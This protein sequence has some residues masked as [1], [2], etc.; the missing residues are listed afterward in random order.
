[1]KGRID[2]TDKGRVL[3]VEELSMV[4]VAKHGG[5]G[6]GGPRSAGGHGGNGTGNG[7]G[8][9]GRSGGVAA[10]Q[11]PGGGPEADSAPTPAHTCRIQVRSGAAVAEALAGALDAVKAACQSH[12]GPTPLF[13][14]VLLPD[15]EI[16]VK[17]GSRVDPGP[18]LV[19]EVERW[20]GPGSVIVEHAGRA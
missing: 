20:L 16:V 8:H 6:N 11:A 4:D 10:R 2:D 1:V 5:A 19:A 3:L 17:A 12:P 14:H 9:D 7:G 18:A 15:R 13:V